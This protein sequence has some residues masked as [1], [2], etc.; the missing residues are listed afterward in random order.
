[1]KSN[2][3]A[4]IVTIVHLLCDTVIIGQFHRLH[5]HLIDEVANETP[6]H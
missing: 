2:Y 6:L 3:R 5:C 1:M 4:A